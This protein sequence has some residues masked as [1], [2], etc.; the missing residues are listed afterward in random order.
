MLKD[1]EDFYFICINET[2]DKFSLAAWTGK[3]FVFYG[4][5]IIPKYYQR[6]NVINKLIERPSG[7]DDHLYIIEIPEWPPRIIYGCKEKE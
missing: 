5:K 3:D 6:A 7:E 1:G 4:E 2:K